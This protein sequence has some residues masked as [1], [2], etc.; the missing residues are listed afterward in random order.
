[1]ARIYMTPAELIAELKN[2]KDE[3]ILVEINSLDNIRND[4]IQQG[5]DEEDPS[6]DVKANHAMIALA[7][8]TTPQEYWD[9]IDSV[10]DDFDQDGDKKFERNNQ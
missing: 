2:Y 9:I 1:M 3:P 10:I 7:D 4:L 8:M 6:L 5:E